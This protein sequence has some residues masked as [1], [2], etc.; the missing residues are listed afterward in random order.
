[1]KAPDESSSAMQDG[2]KTANNLR[3]E[4]QQQQEAAQDIIKERTGA[5]RLGGIKKAPKS[6]VPLQYELIQSKLGKFKNT[7][8]K[9]LYFGSAFTGG[10]GTN[11]GTTSRAKQMISVDQNCIYRVHKVKGIKMMADKDFLLSTEDFPDG[12]DPKKIQNLKAATYRQLKEVQLVAEYVF[13][14]L[15][16]SSRLNCLDPV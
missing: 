13:C 12:E 10:Q 6:G 9:V 8:L 2:L 4:A 3:E 5:L 16:Q 7:E 14:S 11:G 1:V 15:L